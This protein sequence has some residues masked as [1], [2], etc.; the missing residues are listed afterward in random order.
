[1]VS[2]WVSSYIYLSYQSINHEF[3]DVHGPYEIV[4]NTTGPSSIE[5]FASYSGRGYLPGKVCRLWSYNVCML[6]CFWELTS[7]CFHMC[8]K[9]G[10]DRNIL[11]S[12]FPCFLFSA[13]LDTGYN[14]WL[15]IGHV[16]MQGAKGQ[17]TL[18]L[19]SNF[20]YLDSRQQDSPCD[21]LFVVVIQRQGK[22]NKMPYY[23]HES[24]HWRYCGR[25]IVNAR[26]CYFRD[27]P[28]D[29]AKPIEFRCDPTNCSTIRST[30][31]LVR[32]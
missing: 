27:I 31:L 18:H 22:S 10:C 7:S 20:G 17:G 2:I 21:V 11:L 26:F 1:M 29:S 15:G 32:F 24:V 16:Y 23:R 14:T 9:N 13:E 28:R 19:Y 25:N 8:K 3:G 4:G 6:Q 30:L 12:K 5:N